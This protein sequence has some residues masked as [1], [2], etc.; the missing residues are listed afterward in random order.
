[1]QL[2]LFKNFRII[3]YQIK[4]DTKLPNHCNSGL[5]HL[6]ISILKIINHECVVK[7]NN[8]VRL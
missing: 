3:F 6:F 4:D 7:A 5:E 8:N 2:E 1:M